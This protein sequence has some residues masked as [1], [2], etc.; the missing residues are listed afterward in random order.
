MSE[1]PYKF[2]FKIREN[3]RLTSYFNRKPIVNF[4]TQPKVEFPAT[5]AKPKSSHVFFSKTMQNNILKSKPA[6]KS[7][8]LFISTANPDRAASKLVVARLS[9]LEASTPKVEDSII[10]TKMLADQFEDQINQ[11]M[12]N[13]LAYVKRR[14]S[15]CLIEG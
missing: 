3:S 1:S 9:S 6:K 4:L 10:K 7:I 11:H 15:S 12:R 13:L 8:R 5:K 2:E 14:D